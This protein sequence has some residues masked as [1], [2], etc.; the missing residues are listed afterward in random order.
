MTFALIWLTL[1]VAFLDWMAV[2]RQWKQLEYIAKPGTMLF[3]IAWLWV[4]SGFQGS[5]VWFGLGLVFS[6]A[7]DIFLMLPRER[8]VG[9]LVAFLIAHIAYCIGFYTGFPPINI[10]SMGLLILIILV[11]VR[12]YRR[13]AQGLVA[14]G[15][16]G[17][18][19]PVLVYT[20][21]ISLMLYSALITLIRP[22]WEAAS[23]LLVGGGAL[24]FFLSDS[25]LA[26]NK[27][28]A[29]LRH[30]KLIVIV[31]YHIGQILITIGAA[32][33]FLA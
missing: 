30:G 32:S 11:V 10:A 31:T 33:H 2:A 22:E 26:W 25:F 20:L 15:K 24:L 7:G 4:E 13:I 21:V 19:L 12:L 14:S 6:L 5:L 17:L 3:L 16:D 1:A 29:P 27:F 28:V 8:F 23:A 18:K 9:G